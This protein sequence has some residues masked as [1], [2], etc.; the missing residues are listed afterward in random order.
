[1]RSKIL[2][3]CL[4][5]VGKTFAQTEKSQYIGINILQL[6]AFT[7]NAN[8]SIDANPYFSPFIDMGYT[9]NYVKAYNIDLIGD[10]LTR[11]IDLYDGYDIHDMSG[12]YLKVGGFLNFRKIFEK[13][14]Y[15]HFGLFITNSIVHEKGLYL[16]PIDS[17]PYSYANKIEHTVYLLGLSTSIGYELK[18]TD[19]LKSSLDFQLSFPGKKR[20]D[21]YSYNNYISGMGYNGEGG[22]VFPMLILNIKY[23]I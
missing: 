1:M 9:F 20:D 6:P 18:I 19:K 14:H 5:I 10:I 21:L 23:G 8:Y 2:I 17:R 16:S 15:F 7:I 13:E 3:V 11:H 12:G 22:N 4:L